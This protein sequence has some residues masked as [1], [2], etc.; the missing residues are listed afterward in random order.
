MNFSSVGPSHRLQCFTNCSSVGPSHRLQSFWHRLLQLGS[1]TGSQVLPENLFQRGLLSPWVYRS[2][3]E[4]GPAWASHGVTA[5][6]GNPLLRCGV[7]PGLQVEICS[8]VDL[9]GLQGDSLPHRGLPHGLQG[10]LCSSAWSTSSPSF[11][12]DLGVCRVVSL[13]CSHSSLWLQFLLSSNFFPLL[14]YVLPEAL[15]PLL[16]GSD[17]ASGRSVLEPAGIGSVRHRRS[18]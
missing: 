7:L 13:T 18:F 3:L 1:P 6:F 4:P 2:C 5:S 14:K 8:T 9:P 12:T 16:M 17:L 15:P 10:N 11:C